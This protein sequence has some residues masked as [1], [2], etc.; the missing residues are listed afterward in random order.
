MDAL[1]YI[2]E[3]YDDTATR[4]AVFAMIEEETKRYKPTKNYLEYLPPLNLTQF[5]TEVIKNEMERMASG[6]RMPVLSM[7]RYELPEPPSN[8]LTEVSAWQEAVDNSQAQ[9]EHQLN[10]ITNLQ[11][12]NT[13]GTEG[14]KVYNT[15]LLRL[16]EAAQ[17]QLNALKKQIQEINW[18]RKTAQTAAGDKLK[19]LERSWTGLVAKNYEIERT[20]LLIEQEI[21]FLEKK[22]EGR[23]NVV[24]NGKGS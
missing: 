10:R 13:F 22:I 19:A 15:I 14:W 24:V 9:L 5:E 23:E 2:D 11:L 7:K 4:E 1:P 8:R 18:Q 12:M 16:T 3:G 20:C 21:L 6:Q 17:K